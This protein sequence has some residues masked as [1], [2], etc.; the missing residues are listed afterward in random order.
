[1]ILTVGKVNDSLLLIKK[2][3]IMVQ[4]L[5]KVISQKKTLELKKNYTIGLF[6]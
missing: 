6:F 1:M 2:K 5:K 4:V 3:L